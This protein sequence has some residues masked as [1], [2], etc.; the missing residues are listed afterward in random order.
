MQRYRDWQSRLQ[1]CLAERCTR[2]FEWGVLD[3]VLFAADCVEACTGVDPAAAHRGTY[4]DAASAARVVL[5]HGGLAEIAASNLGTEVPPVLAQPGDIGLLLNDG[6][7][8]L[9]V[10]TGATWHAPGAGGVVALPMA[11]AMRAWRLVPGEG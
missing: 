7:E 2:A 1:A 5:A 6:R 9:A 8:C 10:C 3:C 4:S 11:Q